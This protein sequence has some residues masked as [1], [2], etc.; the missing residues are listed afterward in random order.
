MKAR[1]GRGSLIKTEHNVRSYTDNRHRVN[2]QLW[3][4][5]DQEGNEYRKSFEYK[6]N[7][8]NIPL[9]GSHSELNALQ[10]QY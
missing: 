1:L 4:F 5:Y 2:R 3:S 8:P 6:N 9:M 10:I 7:A